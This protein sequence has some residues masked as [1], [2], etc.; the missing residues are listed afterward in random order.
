[1]SQGQH[2]VQ[3]ATKRPYVR[4]LIIRLL[5]ANFRRKVVRRANSSLSA[6]ICVL[7]DSSNAEIAYLD[8]ATLSHENILRLEISVQNLSVVDVFDSESHLDEPIQNLIFRVA[9]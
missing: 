4:F 5:L 7:Q 1:M 2:F 9:N 6:I 3:D 8:L